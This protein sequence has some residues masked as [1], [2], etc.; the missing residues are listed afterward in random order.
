M[1]QQ[2]IENI[3]ELVLIDAVKRRSDVNFD[4]VQLRAGL[5][6]ESGGVNETV[7]ADGDNS[8]VSHSVNLAVRT[9]SLNS[10]SCE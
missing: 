10:F 7:R 3:Y 1:A 5:V 9:L 8:L 6:D 2:L 4:E